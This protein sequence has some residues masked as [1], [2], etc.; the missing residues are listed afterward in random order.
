MGQKANTDTDTVCVLADWAEGHIL[1]SIPVPLFLDQ[2]SLIFL[3]GSQVIA[4]FLILQTFSL[5]SWSEDIFQ[6]LKCV[7]GFIDNYTPDF[8]AA[9]VKINIKNWNGEILSINDLI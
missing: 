5:G 2:W 3:S 9:A 8:G 6:S 1:S 7:M 4:K